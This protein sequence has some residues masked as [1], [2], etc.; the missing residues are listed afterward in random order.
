M[1]YKKMVPEKIVPAHEEHDYTECDRCKQ[2]THEHTW[3]D[4]TD[5]ASGYSIE[6]TTVR[7]ESGSNY[8]EGGSSTV[9]EYHLCPECFKDLIHSELESRGI[10]GTQEEKD[11]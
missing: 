2:R 9:I 5:W 6:R 10:V 3:N 7:Y 4:A 8:P 1:K 11:W